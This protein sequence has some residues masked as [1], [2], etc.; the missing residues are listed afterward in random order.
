MPSG[1][2]PDS[3][4]HGGPFL[5]F[6]ERGASEMTHDKNKPTKVEGC[7]HVNAKCCRENT[8]AEEIINA[9]DKPL[10]ELLG[11]P[12]GINPEDRTKSEEPEQ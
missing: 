3:I 6:H 4:H 10:T 11:E 12:D 8:V 2:D 1:P 9:E 7:C 5:L